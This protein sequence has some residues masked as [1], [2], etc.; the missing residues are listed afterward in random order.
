MTSSNESELLL[1]LRDIGRLDTANL[2]NGVL[3][4]SLL[5]GEAICK[6]LESISELY[7]FG[8][9]TIVGSGLKEA[10]PIADI[11]EH[12]GLEVTLSLDVPQTRQ[13]FFAE[14][15]QDMVSSGHS[16]TSPNHFYIYDIDYLSTDSN[17]VDDVAKY[18]SVLDF[19]DFMNTRIE[20]DHLET[21]PDKNLVVYFL[22]SQRKLSLPLQYDF[23][24]LLLDSKELS[25]SIQKLR[26]HFAEPFHSL[27]KQQLFKA[28]LINHLQFQ[29]ESDRFSFLI[30]RLSEFTKAFEDNYELF[31]SQFSYEDEIDNIYEQRRLYSAKLNEILSGIQTKLLAIPLPFLIAGTQLNPPSVENHIIS[32]SFVLAGIFAFLIIIVLLLKAQLTL[33]SAIENEISAKKIR[34]E[35]DFPKLS[36]EVGSEFYELDLMAREVRRYIIIVGAL[37]VLSFIFSTIIYSLFLW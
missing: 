33:L 18:L 31:V 1:L 11:E 20:H 23:N 29:G 9:L 15:L 26:H 16:Y 30:N 25:S 24:A 7:P 6:N 2:A 12:I 27:D 22:N 14:N 21:L 35:N 10:I 17:I 19:V 32:N 28:T 37:A 5:L 3:T 34:L 4:A 36:E 8:D 13:A